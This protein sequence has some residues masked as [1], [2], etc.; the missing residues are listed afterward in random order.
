MPS[1]QN[2]TVKHFKPAVPAPRVGTC[3]GRSI[4]QAFHPKLSRAKEA[5]RR[6]LAT[7][8]GAFMVGLPAY[9]ILTAPNSVLGV[10]QWV[11]FTIVVMG[12]APMYL[13]L[14]DRNRSPV[15]FFPM[16]TLYNCAAYGLSTLGDRYE[17]P[18]WHLDAIS[19]KA[20]LLALAG[21][22][23]M[24]A[25][26]YLSK[27]R[28]HK[29]ISP[30]KLPGTVNV[31][32]LRVLMWCFLG[33]H[34]LFTQV[35]AIQVIAT[36]A[37]FQ[38][39]TGDIGFAICLFLWRR[40]LLPRAES[41][42][43]IGVVAPLEILMLFTSGL[44]AQPVFFAFL[45]LGVLWAT[46]RVFPWKTVALGLLLV[47]AL[48]SVKSEY[49]QIAWGFG[50]AADASP[51]TKAILFSRLLVDRLQTDE[52]PA[53]TAPTVIERIGM[54]RFLSTIV[55]QTPSAVPY[56]KGESYAGFLYSAIPRVIWPG[57]PRLDSGYWFSVR[58]G[59]RSPGDLLTS[60]NVPWLIEAYANFGFLG[61]TLGMFLIGI[62]LAVVDRLFNSSEMTPLSL[63]VGIS[64]I[65]TMVYQESSFTQMIG[66]LLPAAIAF[67]V[68]F[69]STLGRS[70]RP[71]RISG[72]PISPA[73][74]LPRRAQ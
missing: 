39:Y 14:K 72:T 37:Q 29:T 22:G 7:A 24:I 5:R 57:K 68:L 51:T 41:L 25:G 50:S 67:H 30:Y 10:Q 53:Q 52:V 31:G 3:E 19:T 44:L 65:H 20:T 26:F 21:L 73:F 18:G 38:V 60:I 33:C 48:N 58:Y 2:K 28:I 74:P 40:R 47:F 46:E 12:C 32:S 71:S 56:L 13:Y 42:I 23:F 34:L 69:H 49:R 45:L 36:F 15:P 70:P 9:L 61:I 55:D 27:A 11:G 17:R 8:F 64:L 66:G 6:T 1:P 63:L 59:L 4:F 62:V 16:A 54:I 43:L 35:P